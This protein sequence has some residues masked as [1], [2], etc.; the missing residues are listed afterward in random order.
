MEN[1]K[2]EK[3]VE[4]KITNSWRDSRNEFPVAESTSAYP[5][6]RKQKKRRIHRRCVDMIM[7]TE[8]LTLRG[9]YRFDEN[10]TRVYNEF[11]SMLS[12]FDHFDSVSFLIVF[13]YFL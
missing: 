3:P 4:S 2:N 13:R 6:S 7:P 5:A 8:E 1:I 10:Q 11:V 9:L 12:Q